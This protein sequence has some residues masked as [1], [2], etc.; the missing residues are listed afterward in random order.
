MTP[1]ATTTYPL[2]WITP[3]M[4]VGYA[5]HSRADIE[6]LK[7]CGI[8][9]V[10]NLC[11]E[12]YDLNEIE[13]AEGLEVHWLPVAD[14]DAPDSDL[15]QQ[16]IQWLNG[17]LAQHKKVLVH[18]RFGIGR[19]GTMVTAWLL[20]QGYTLE[21]AQ[22]MLGHTPAKP[23]SRRQWDFLDA[24]SRSIGKPAVKRPPDLEQRRSRLGRF[25][26]KYA[27]MNDWWTR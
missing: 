3:D 14:E 20:D 4:A 19:T 18:C 13:A 22:D 25:F 16:A 17:I 9:A 15:A 5:P 11:A 10:L 27:R 21:D 12:C 1:K 6:A 2:K 7:A 8:E 23:N 26:R 24:Y